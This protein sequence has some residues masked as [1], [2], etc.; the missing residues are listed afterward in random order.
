MKF[1]LAQMVRRIRNPRRNSINIRTIAP[2]V[3]QEADLAAIY[4]RVVRMLA[5]EAK[6]RLLPAYVAALARL[7]ARDS[8]VRDDVAQVETVQASIEE[9]LRRLVITLTPEMRR[10]LVR[11][12]EAH[13]RKWIAGVLT[14]TTVDLSVFI[15]PEG[16][17]ETL[18]A[19]LARNVALIRDLD[20]QARGRIADAVFRG[21]QNRSPA[22]LVAKAIDEA[23]QLGRKRALRIAADQ[24]Q[25]LSAALD[26]ERMR[27]AGITHWIWRHSGKLHPRPEHVARDGRVYTDTTAPADLPG[28]LPFCGCKRQAHLVFAD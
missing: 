28:E 21:L 10:L 24:L 23:L 6:A 12:E 25:K 17:R 1:D 9:Q 16:A 18:G 27:E 20:A 4:L 22:R 14:A 8:L 7:E 26:A 13:R 5:E 15:G 11:L 19:V 2:T 3:V